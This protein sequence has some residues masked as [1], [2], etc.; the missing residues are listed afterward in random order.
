M[1]MRPE[2]T[3]LTLVISGPKSPSKNIDVFLHPLIDDL[4]RL[5][6]S[7]I[8]TFDSFRKQN[9]TIRAMLMWT[10]TDF[11][12]Y[13]MVSGWSTH[14]RLSCPYCME[15][16]R[17]FYLQYGCKIC[18]FDCHRQFLPTSHSYRMDASQFLKGHLE[19]DPPPPRLDGHSV[20][21]R[22]A[23]LPDVLF[24]NPSVNQKILKFG[25]TH[26]WVK[27]SIFWELS[28]WG[29]NLI[30]QNLDV[31]HYLETS[32]SK[33]PRNFAAVP[34]YKNIEFSIFACPGHPMGSHSQTRCLTTQEMK[35]AELYVLL[36]CREVDAL[37]RGTRI[38]QVYNIDEVNSRYQLST[39]EP[40]CFA[41]QATQVYYS[42]YPSDNRA[43]RGWFAA[44]KIRARHLVDASSTSLDMEEI[45]QDEEPPSV[46]SNEHSSNL[47]STE[48]VNLHAEGATMVDLNGD[49]NDDLDENTSEGNERYET[50]GD[51]GDDSSGPINSARSRSTLGRRKRHNSVDL[52][53][54]VTLR[55]HTRS[56]SPQ[57]SIHAA[58][59]SHNGKQKGR[60]LNKPKKA[61]RRPDERPFIQISHKGT[62]LDVEV[63]RLITTLWKRVYEGDYFTYDLFPE[64]KRLQVWQLFKTHYQWGLEDE[65]AVRKA[66]LR[67]MKKGWGDNMK[68]ER[69]KWRTNV[70]VGRKTEHLGNEL[71]TLQ[72]LI[73]MSLSALLH[74]AQTQHH[75]HLETRT[76]GQLLLGDAT[77]IS[78]QELVHREAMQ[79]MRD[80]IGQ[81]KEQ[82]ETMQ[83]I[84][85]DMGRM[86]ASLSQQFA[87]F[88]AYGMRP[89][90]AT[91]S[92]PHTGQAFPLV[93]TSF[94]TAGPSFHASEPSF[95]H[96][97]PM[98]MPIEPSFPMD[99]MGRQ[100]GSPST[101]STNPPQDD[102]GYQPR[103]DVD[104]QGPFG[105]R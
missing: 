105:P 47:A 60:G 98:Q 42:S 12:R 68:D 17:A 1:C 88:S 41:C 63:P 25:E 43:T 28:Y 10:I 9:F 26:N 81:V 84:L 32:R 3:F 2:F 38:N 45:F 67:S 51:V 76:L 96:A 102:Y 55:I 74:M 34:F 11:P 80:E 50:R 85:E 95:P 90:N 72:D 94:P 20:R 87:A 75:G 92:L 49:A 44:C 103:F 100:S 16:T 52:A 18:F 24:G 29:D 73:H 77:T 54:D 5:W 14:G 48:R 59:S 23:A 91:P 31:M 86:Q 79:M 58:A 21:L 22:V 27:Q 33:P 15:M 46:Q 6:S 56:I 8:E 53:C 62:F 35:A 37:L 93:G 104:Y 69:N 83:R 89:P 78:C 39:S 99:Q 65:D 36:N 66:F 13:G 57:G 61:A 4:K 7:G 97:M 70:R 71:H 19:F 101:S 64:Q 40:F 30:R 82:R